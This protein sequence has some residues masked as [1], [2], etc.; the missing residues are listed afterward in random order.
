MDQPIQTKTHVGG[1]FQRVVSRGVIEA[2]GNVFNI[3]SKVF[4]LAFDGG[5]VDP[6]NIMECRGRFRGS[7]WVGLEGLRWILDVFIKLC[8]LNQKLEGFFEFHR[9]GHRILE[10]SCLPNRRGRFV[11]V[12]EYHNGTHRGSIRISGGQ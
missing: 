12:T 10:F 3:D 5:R 2:G 6:H 9:D 4:T 1:S 7:L 8:N 11:E